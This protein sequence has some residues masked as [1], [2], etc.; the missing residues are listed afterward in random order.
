MNALIVGILPHNLFGSATP[1][2]L[3][4]VGILALIAGVLLLLR[5]FPR[6][7]TASSA[8]RS[9]FHLTTGSVPLILIGIILIVVGLSR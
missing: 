9:G 6:G 2:V 1:V 8:G 4:V 3:T 5:G 7:S